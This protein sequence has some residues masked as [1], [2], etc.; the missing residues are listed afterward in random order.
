VNTG[1]NLT[2]KDCNFGAFHAVLLF[3]GVFHRSVF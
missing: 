2:V 3:L 1:M